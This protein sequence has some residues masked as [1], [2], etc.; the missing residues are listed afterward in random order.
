MVF[1]VKW[2]CRR[3]FQTGGDVFLHLAFR[4]QHTPP[5][6]LSRTSEVS[7]FRNVFVD[8]G[9]LPL[10]MP[11]EIQKSILVLRSVITANL[12]HGCSNH[13]SQHPSAH[14]AWKNLQPF[15]FCFVFF[16]CEIIVLGLFL[17]FICT[18]KKLLNVLI[19]VKLTWLRES[20]CLW[21]TVPMWVLHLH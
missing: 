18:K 2:V 16:L 7:L 9:L 10:Y 6:P 5:H 8:V 11:A 15:M 21:G 12:T 4:G 19:I 3:S 17:S 1:V 20:C 13:Y 14:T